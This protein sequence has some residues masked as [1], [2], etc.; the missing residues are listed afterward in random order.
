MFALSG[1]ISTEEKF[2]KE[3]LI[4]VSKYISGKQPNVFKNLIGKP[5][6]SNRL[7]SS[8]KKTF[9]IDPKLKKGNLLFSILNEWNKCEQ[10]YRDASNPKELIKL[11]KEHNIE[12]QKMR[13]CNAKHCFFC[14]RDK[15]A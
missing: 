1:I 10:I 8:D 13:Q 6:E 14:E 3:S 7:R 9:K 4:F 2:K 15:A 11:F 12:T 5:V